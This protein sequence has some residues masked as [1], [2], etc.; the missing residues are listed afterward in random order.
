MKK[1]IS[2]NLIE[3]E[4]IGMDYGVFDEFNLRIIKQL[5]ISIDHYGRTVGLDFQFNDEFS[6]GSFEKRKEIVEKYL[7]ENIIESL[8]SLLESIQNEKEN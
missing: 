3:V 6:K 1:W 8:V 4:K 5:L 2:E 7:N